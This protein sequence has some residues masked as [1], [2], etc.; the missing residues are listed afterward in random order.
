M[1]TPELVAAI[2]HP[3]SV[4]EH[5]FR[6]A[7]IGYLLAS[8]E[9]ADPAR[10]ALLCLFHDSQESRIGDVP[11]VGSA[12]WSRRRT[13]SHRRPGRRVPRGDR[14]GRP[15]AGRRLR[16]PGLAEARLARDADKLDA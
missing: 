2:E 6:T 15:R 14:S 12:M 10:T 1:A 11:L 5:S 4:A 16:A 7:V 3:E 9:G 13:T 8:I